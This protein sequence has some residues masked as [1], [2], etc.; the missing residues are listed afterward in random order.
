MK[1]FKSFEAHAELSEFTGLAQA[2]SHFNHPFD[3]VDYRR[4]PHFDDVY[5]LFIKFAGPRKGEPQIDATFAPKRTD[6]REE[7]SKSLVIPNLGY[8]GKYGLCIYNTA[9][10]EFIEEPATLD[11][12]ETDLEKVRKKYGFRPDDETNETF[13]PKKKR[14][15]PNKLYPEV[16]RVF[17]GK[18]GMFDVSDEEMEKNIGRYIIFKREPGDSYGLIHNFVHKIVA[19]QKNYKGD[20]CYRVVCVEGPYAGSPAANFGSVADP[21]KIEILPKDYVVKNEMVK[22]EAFENIINEKFDTNSV[23]LIGKGTVTDVYTDGKFA[24]SVT[25]NFNSPS[26]EE[27]KKH[28][29]KNYT[30]VVH[31][32]DAWIDEDDTI[33]KMEI[34]RPIEENFKGDKKE[35]YKIDSELW[36]M[37]D[38]VVR[39]EGLDQETEDP[40]IKK[41]LLAILNGAKEL[42]TDVLD[43]G[44]HNLMYDPNTDEYKLI[45][46]F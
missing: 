7:R 24:Y 46:I 15:W 44:F 30:N 9:T 37:Q 11:S 36:E 19:I 2:A 34:L 5:L 22:F 28:I 12:Y 31:I 1:R 27:I 18:G 4:D 33:I 38:E 32:Y 45:D 14:E 23:D 17:G 35:L 40:Q 16:K 43:L 26:I 13:E 29:G 21:D 42:K 20:L 25:S 8:V 10:Q 3:I 6:D 41:M 39:V